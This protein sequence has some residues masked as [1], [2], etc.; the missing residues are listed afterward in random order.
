MTCNGRAGVPISIIPEC[1]SAGQELGWFLTQEIRI[2][3]GSLYP[4]ILIIRFYDD[5]QHLASPWLRPWQNVGHHSG[6]AGMNRCYRKSVA[7]ADNLTGLDRLSFRYRWLAHSSMVLFHGQNYFLGQRKGFDLVVL[8]LPFRN[9]H[10]FKRRF[11]PHENPS[12]FLR[13]A[14]NLMRRFSETDM[15]FECKALGGSLA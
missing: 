11:F 2:G 1:L 7:F 5:T 10:S 4:F 13:V 6:D 9:I 14:L 3:L 8:H 12:K 15:K